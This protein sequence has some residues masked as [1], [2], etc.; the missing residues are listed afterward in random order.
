MRHRASGRARVHDAAGPVGGCGQRI[1]SCVASVARYPPRGVDGRFHVPASQ[2]VNGGI[3]HSHAAAGQPPGELFSE[4]VTSSSLPLR[5]QRAGSSRRWR[6][7]GAANWPLLRGARLLGS[8]IVARLLAWWACPLTMLWWAGSLLVL[9]W[10]GSLTVLWWS[11]RSPSI[12]ARRS[13]TPVL[14]LGGRGRMP[15]PRRHRRQSLHSN[16]SRCRLPR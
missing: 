10:A 16:V 13:S 14:R 11:H 5:G 12:H 1:W 15:G 4:G 3:H 2:P 9:W 8:A 6:A 7:R